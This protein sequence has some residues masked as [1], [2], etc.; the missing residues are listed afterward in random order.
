LQ[1]I[2]SVSFWYVWYFLEM[3]FDV[4]WWI[5]PCLFDLFCHFVQWMLLL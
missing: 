4:F 2:S 5:C 3:S 1:M